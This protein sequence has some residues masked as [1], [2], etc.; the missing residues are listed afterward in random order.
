M[1]AMNRATPDRTDPWHAT[2][3][4][5]QIPESGLHREIEA[6]PAV[7]AAMAEIAG[8][9]EI[10]SARASF[11]MSLRSGGRVHVAGS[12]KARIGQTCVVTLD[13]VEND[14]DEEIDLIFAPE[15][16]ISYATDD[17]VEDAEGG[18]RK[19][20]EPPEPI[21]NGAIDLGRLA[22]DVLYLAIDPY[23]R[24]P[25]AVFEPQIAAA[26]PEDRP[27]AALKGLKVAPKKPKSGEKKDS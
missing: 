25:G 17:L 13:P 6:G 11:D 14:I 1:Q 9:R 27:F 2:V 12:V 7:R 20:P 18:E 21:V 22:T 26:D 8:L 10:S 3:N 15:Q 5:T 4:V 16:Q 23:P 19:L 24:K